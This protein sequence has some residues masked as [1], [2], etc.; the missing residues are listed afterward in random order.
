[1]Q[2]TANSVE[3]YLESLPEERRIAVSAVRAVILKNLPTGYEETMNWGMICYEVPLHTN[4]DTYNKKPLMYAALGSQ[5]NHMAVYLSGVYCD[6]SLKNS[7][8]TAY[9]ATGKK[10]D[11]GK[12]CV[13][14][15]KLENLPLEVIGQAIASQEMERFIQLSNANRNKK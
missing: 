6:E 5:K 12:S 7:F 14:F 8:E 13:R 4:P 3:E 1:M 10:M 9:K 11:M 2:S 15:K